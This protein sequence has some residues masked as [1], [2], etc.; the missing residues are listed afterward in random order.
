MRSVGDHAP[1]FTLPGVRGD[2]EGSQVHPH[3]LTDALETGPVLLNFYLF[4]FHPHCT[5]NVCDLQNLAWFDIGGEVSVFAISTDRA[6]SH[7]A[8]ATEEGL[9]VTLLSDSDGSVAKKY[10]VLYDEYGGHKRIA[11][12]SVFLIG[13]NQEIEYAWETED[14]AVQPDWTAVKDAIEARQ[15]TEPI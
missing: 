12:R 10:D 13:E 11:R 9:S 6:F 3:S 4:D 2:D 8:F 15:A 1:G 14:P 7:R 5:E